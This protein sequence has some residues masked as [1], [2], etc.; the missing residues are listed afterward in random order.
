MQQPPDMHV[1]RAAVIACRAPV[2][3]KK[4]CRNHA[5]RREPGGYAPFPYVVLR[6][7][8]FAALRLQRKLGCY[9]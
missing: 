9:A 5:K 7:A 6:S 1:T 8:E 4:K 3:S 2:S